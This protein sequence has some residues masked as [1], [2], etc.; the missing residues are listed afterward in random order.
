[1]I[2][3]CS[4]PMESNLPFTIHTGHMRKIPANVIQLTHKPRWDGKKLAELNQQPSSTA[5]SG[6]RCGCHP[7]LTHPPLTVLHS[8][9]SHSFHCSTSHVLDELPSHRRST[10]GVGRDNVD[11]NSGDLSE[12]HRAEFWCGRNKGRGSC[13]EKRN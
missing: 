5:G 4:G 6:R 1:M 12:G 8:W 10:N 3:L 11:L 9:G 7:A 2:S 13:V